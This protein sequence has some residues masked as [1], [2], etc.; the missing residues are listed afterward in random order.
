MLAMVSY[1]RPPPSGQITC[2]LNRTYHVL[3][4]RLRY[5]VDSPSIRWYT[6]ATMSHISITFATTVK[7]LAALALLSATFVAPRLWADIISYSA[8]SFAPA[9]SL[10]STTLDSCP[11]GNPVCVIVTIRFIANTANIV[12]FSV[13]GAS[14][15]EN[16]V[17]QG[18]VDLFNDQTG[19][20]LSANFLANQIYVSVD[21]TNDGIGFGSAVGPTYPLG[22]YSGT[23]SIPYSSYDLKSNFTLTNGFAWFCP[24]GTCTL[25]QA[26]PGLGTDQ[27]LLSITPTG[28]VFGSSFFATVIQVTPVPEPSTML[29]FATVTP[30][31]IFRRGLKST[32]SIL[33]RRTMR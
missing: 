26:G 7:R 27:G 13:V 8:T 32:L 23:P 16:F 6:N 28:P 30:A 4:T 11:V 10:G 12:P 15:Y 33:C 29:L 31:F 9:A 17:G 21:Q 5:L 25:G 19:Q 22:V 14:G 1:S 2:Y 24:A 18:S 3:L 20:S